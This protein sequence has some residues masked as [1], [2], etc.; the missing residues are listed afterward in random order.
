VAFVQ[1]QATMIDNMG[2]QWLAVKASGLKICG[3]G[4]PWDE[5]PAYC[6]PKTRSGADLTM[7]SPKVPQITV[8]EFAPSDG[9]IIE[10]TL[11]S[12]TNVTLTARLILASGAGARDWKTVDLTIPAITLPR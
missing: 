1:P 6:A 12:A 10:S 4:K 9:G 8:M 2:N 11:A 5:T 7:L 3:Y